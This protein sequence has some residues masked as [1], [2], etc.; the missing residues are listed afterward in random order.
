MKFQP[1]E[2]LDSARPV[3]NSIRWLFG[4]ETCDLRVSPGL[5]AEDMM[6]GE[7]RGKVSFLP[8]EPALRCESSQDS[9]ANG[10]LQQRQVS[11]IGQETMADPTAFQDVA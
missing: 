2:S 8:S 5:Q 9:M 1:L 11:T 3:V 10:A 4:N 6:E 7:V